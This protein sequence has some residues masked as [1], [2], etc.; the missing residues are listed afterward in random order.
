MRKY[1]AAAIRLVFLLALAVPLLAQRERQIAPPSQSEKNFFEQLRNLFGRF[2]ETDLRRAFQTARPIRCSELISDTGE[3]RPVAFFNE[4]R[5]L[6]EWYHRSLEEV[7]AELSVYTFKGTCKTDQDSVQVLTK[8]PVQDS[9]NRYAAGRIALKDVDVNVNA[10]VTASYNPRT[11]GYR[12]ELPYLYS[13]RGNSVFSLLALTKTDRYATTVLNHWDCKSVTGN[14]VTFQFLICE[15]AT[16]PRNMPRGSEAD[17]S[18]GTYAYFILSDGKEAS[19]SMKLSF[20]TPGNE[21]NAPAA[22]EPDTVAVTVK[23]DARGLPQGLEGWQIPGVATKLAEVDKTEFRIRFSPQTWA[24]RIGVAQ[25]LADQKMSIFDPAKPPAGV[26]YC[27]WRPASASVAP[28]VL[29]NEPDVDVAYS[30]TATDASI[31]F[32]MKTHIGTRVGALQCFFP[33]AEIGAI[34]F[35]RWVAVVGAHLTI[36]ARP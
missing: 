7:N 33:G 35:D 15:T 29:G 12:F 2:R 31:S 30:L 17:Q 20:G 25:V 16:L 13:T 18:F 23:D 14:D 36:E 3:W 28:R 27:A 32:D 11:Q 19:T 24:N 34:S 26:D 5:K 8:F 9:Q 4:D 10:P 22:P 1:S 21:D 6:G